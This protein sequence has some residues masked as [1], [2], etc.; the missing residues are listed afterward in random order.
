MSWKMNQIFHHYALPSRYNM[1]KPMKQEGTTT[2]LVN[3]TRLPC[4]NIL[5]KVCKD[6]ENITLMA[7][8]FEIQVERIGKTNIHTPYE[9]HVEGLT[10]SY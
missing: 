5:C 9:D 3:T 2:S 6:G 7:H 4:V 8:N 1:E 10:I